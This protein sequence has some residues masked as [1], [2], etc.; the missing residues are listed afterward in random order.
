MMPLG[1]WS[2]EPQEFPTEDD[3]GIF[4]PESELLAWHKKMQGIHPRVFTPE[5]KLFG[6]DHGQHHYGTQLATCFDDDPNKPMHCEVKGSKWESQS[7]MFKYVDNREPMYVV[8]IGGEI[9]QIHLTSAHEEG[10]WNKVGHNNTKRSVRSED[11]ERKLVDANEEGIDSTDCIN[12]DACGKPGPSKKCSSCQTAYYC[13]LKCHQNHEMMHRQDCQTGV[14]ILK[15]ANAA[16]LDTEDDLN[17]MPLAR[18]QKLLSKA[19]DYPDDSKTRHDLCGDGLDAIELHEVDYLGGTG[20]EDVQT[21]YIKAQ[22]MEMDGRHGLEAIETAKKLVAIDASIRSNVHSRTP[23][24][25]SEFAASI[26]LAGAYGRAEKWEDAMHLYKDLYTKIYDSVPNATPPEQRKIIMGMSRCLYE[27]G[28]YEPSIELGFCAVEM[29]R[30]FP[31]VY[32]Y[33]ALS[34][35]AR[36]NMDEAVKLAG[37]AVLYES[38]W[39]EHNKAAAKTF[40]KKI[41]TQQRNMQQIANH[42]TGHILLLG[43]DDDLFK[44]CFGKDA[45]WSCKIKSLPENCTRDVL[46]KA[47]SEPDLISVAFQDFDTHYQR[48]KQYFFQGGFLVYFGIY[49]EYTAPGQL[50]RDLKMGP[51]SFSAYTN[52]EYKLTHKALEKLGNKITEQQYTKGNLVK[53]PVIDRLMV[54][55][56]V[57]FEEYKEE[58]CDSGE[59]DYEEQ[60]KKAPASY[61]SYINRLGEQ[62][63]L[64]MHKASHGGEVLYLGFVNGDGN[65]PSIVRALLSRNHS[66]ITTE[67]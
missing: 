23:T 27:L 16:Q 11:D 30:T 13:N 54:P 10:G 67:P 47:L 66:T 17:M 61:E 50:S 46:D 8:L 21:L 33:I 24:M 44:T 41:S 40:Y 37:H 31:G 22:L 48:L 19:E 12:C 36:G 60:V 26:V 59:D 4:I 63:P 3:D 29:N 2:D 58:N 55:K 53:A 38:P 62:S 14:W 65:V 28:M 64:V 32:K 56:G 42:S 52:H 15:E 51:W 18:A 25:Q 9:S 49:G 34:E 43:I 1:G 20:V 35:K 7:P 39:N 45:S 57:S 6:E 5:D